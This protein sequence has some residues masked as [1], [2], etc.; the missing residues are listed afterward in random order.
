MRLN[1]VLRRSSL[2][3]L[4]PPASRKINE[5]GIFFYVFQNLFGNFTPPPIFLRSIFFMWTVFFFIIG[6]KIELPC[7]C[8]YFRLLRKRLSLF[9]QLSLILSGKNCTPPHHVQPLMK[10]LL[11]HV[12]DC[13]LINLHLRSEYFIGFVRFGTIMLYCVLCI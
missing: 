12:S 5:I 1:L 13:D 2:L 7:P 4:T 10:I 6:K 8:W 9:K 3:F 11:N